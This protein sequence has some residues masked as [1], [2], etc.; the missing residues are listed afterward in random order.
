[1][2]IGFTCRWFAIDI[3]Y[4]P[5]WDESGIWFYGPRREKRG[6]CGSLRWEWSLRFWYY[7]IDRKRVWRHRPSEFPFR[8]SRRIRFIP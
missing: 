5:K 8:G 1:M 2:A 6:R 4:S 7:D 3:G